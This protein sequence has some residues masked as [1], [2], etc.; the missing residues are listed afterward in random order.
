MKR[1]TGE[2]V[3][4]RSDL[5]VRGFYGDNRFVLSMTPYLGKVLTIKDYA[6]WAG[7]TVEEN[8]WDWTEEMLCEV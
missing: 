3:R 1:K 4:V 5:V 8:D 6:E 7:Y 2:K